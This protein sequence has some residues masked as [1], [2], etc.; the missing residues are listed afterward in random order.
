MMKDDQPPE[1]ATA[2]SDR[3][4]VIFDRIHRS[5]RIPDRYAGRHPPLSFRPRT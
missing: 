1:D 3:Q 4:H 2:K 5:P